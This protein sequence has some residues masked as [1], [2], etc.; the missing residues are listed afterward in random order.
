M[1]WDGYCSNACCSRCANSSCTWTVHL[2]AEDDE[3]LTQLNHYLWGG[4]SAQSRSTHT[5]LC[6]TRSQFVL[7]NSLNK[8]AGISYFEVP[9]AQWGYFTLLW[10]NNNTLRIN[11]TNEI[12]F[13]NTFMK[14]VQ[15]LT[16]FWWDIKKE[17]NV[18][19]ISCDENVILSE[20][21]PSDGKSPSIPHGPQNTS[22]SSVIKSPTIYLF[23]KEAPSN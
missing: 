16:E 5:V 11:T 7:N 12:S 8:E 22:L 1:T 6:R 20:I 9:G 10:G 13:W 18:K 3:S 14:S 15:L 23:L 4:W 21:L 2:L 17:P 19:Y